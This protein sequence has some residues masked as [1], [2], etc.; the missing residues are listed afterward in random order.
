[1]KRFAIDLD[2]TTKSKIKAS[3]RTVSISTLERYKLLSTNITEIQDHIIEEEEDRG[4]LFF[5]ED[6]L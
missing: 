4:S 6:Q 1:M 5:P 2:Q 3:W